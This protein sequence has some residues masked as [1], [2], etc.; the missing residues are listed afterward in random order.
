LATKSRW[1]EIGLITRDE[2]QTNCCYALQDKTWVSDP[3]GN[4]WEVFVVLEDNL[5][6]NIGQAQSAS[7]C[8]PT[9]V[10]IESKSQVNTSS[11]C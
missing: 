6:E 3:D 7:C 11:C 4:E 1:E 2:M 9:P 8:A 10:G 5:A